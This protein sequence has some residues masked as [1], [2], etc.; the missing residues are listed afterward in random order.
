ML[1]F[2]ASLPRR[3]YSPFMRSGARKLGTEEQ[4]YASALR[5]LMRRAHSVFEMR[6]HLERRAEDAALV[7]TVMRRLKAAGYL[8]D[9]RYAREFTR[10]RA[11][12]RRQG[13]FRIARELRKRGI[14]DRHISAAAE[15]IFAE[16]DETA[17]IRQRIQ[18]RLR[19][20]AA[21]AARPARVAP[22][23]TARGKRVRPG[24][25]ERKKMASLYRSLLAAG[26]P[27]DLIRREMRGVT[28]LPV[29]ELP[30]AE[31]AHGIEE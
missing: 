27:S 4:L 23:D 20:L 3:P 14:P 18:R 24:D 25:A 10:S 2:L 12:G 16:A 30:E 5:A 22:S 1:A 21:K 26:F 17:M 7:P 31:A 9:A 28:S 29:E 19:S 13:R 11:Q 8:D 6:T 15:E